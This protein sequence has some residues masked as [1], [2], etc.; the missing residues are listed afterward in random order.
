MSLLKNEIHAFTLGTTDNTNWSDQ[1]FQKYCGKKC[2]QE[3]FKSHVFEVKV[4][5]TGAN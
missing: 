3:T 4:W 5:K 1:L 2:N